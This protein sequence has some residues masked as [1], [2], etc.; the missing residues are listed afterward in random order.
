MA[1][2]IRLD[3]HRQV[4]AAEGEAVLGV[5]EGVAVGAE[6]GASVGAEVGAS[7]ENG[8][9]ICILSC[10]SVL[11]KYTWLFSQKVIVAFASLV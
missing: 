7:V 6:V 11:V 3:R 8:C 1:P 9:T 2:V 10:V 4:G 5:T